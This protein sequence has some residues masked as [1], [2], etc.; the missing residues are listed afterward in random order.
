M[1]ITQLKDILNGAVGKTGIIDQVTGTAP[2][3]N[4]DLSNI[5]DIG[6]AVLDY[7]G[8]SNENYDSFMRNLIDQVGKIVIVNRAYTSQAP[9]IIKD[10]WE[11]G[12]IM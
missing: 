2:V 3:A 4:E 1:K 9:N 12:S 7:T 5:V 6:K 11:Y 10:S 8:Q